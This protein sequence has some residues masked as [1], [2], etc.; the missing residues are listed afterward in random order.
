MIIGDRLRNSADPYSGS[1]AFTFDLVSLPGRNGLG[2][3]VSLAYFGRVEQAASTWNLDAPTGLAGLGWHLPVQRIL[4]VPNGVAAYGTPQYFLTGIG[5]A[6]RLLQSGVDGVKR[7]FTLENWLP[8]KITYDPTAERWEILDE[9]GTLSVYGDLTLGGNAS[10]VT[11]LPSRFTVEANVR[12]G[13]WIGPSNQIQDQRRFVTAWNL[14]EVT[15]RFGDQVVWYYESVEVATATDQG[16]AFTAASYPVRI[17]ATDGQSVLFTYED[18]TAAE[19]QQPH[20]N[21]PPP[22]AWQDRI[23]TRCLKSIDVFA[24]NGQ[25]LYS[26]VFDYGAPTFLGT[27]ALTKRLLLGINR[28][29]SGGSALPGV[30]FEYWGQDG[31][32]GVS[33]THLFNGAN[34]ALY[35]AIKRA[36]LPEGGTY[37]WEYQ[38]LTPAQ[39]ERAAVVAR[40][41]LS[42]VTFSRPRVLF[43]DA[44]AVVAW[45]GTGSQ[46]VMA[47]QAFTW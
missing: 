9:N 47:V 12:W 38:S 11:R 43:S 14:A 21:P 19:D 6:N 13:N 22:N 41:V 7:I 24:A 4:A 5:G 29:R 39:S 33:A 30:K 2:V 34:G 17:A 40:P 44:Y 46:A 28:T 35:G 37:T 3:R 10:E 27:G 16:L 42:G 26:D 31:S 36:T 15:D 8:W 20:T 23:A 25:P 32:D 45:L 18:K 1:S